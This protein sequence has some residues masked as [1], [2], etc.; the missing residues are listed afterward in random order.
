MVF[1]IVF[2]FFFMYLL[3][4]DKFFYTVAFNSH[5][6]FFLSFIYSLF[7]FIRYFFL[8][9]INSPGYFS[10]MAGFIMNRDFSLS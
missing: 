6:I 3:L 4:P 2:L 9:K 5:C 8:F 1:C 7:P 10:C